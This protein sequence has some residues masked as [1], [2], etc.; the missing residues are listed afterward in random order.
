MGCL[1]QVFIHDHHGR[2]IYFETYSGQAPLGEYVLGLFEK[3]EDSLE[4]P[5]PKLPVTRAIVLDAGHNSVR[6]LRAFAA[7]EKYHYITSLDANQWNPRRVRKQGPPERYRW[8]EAT[9]WDAELELEDSRP[10][11]KGYIFVTRA[12]KIEW[13][14]GKETYLATSVPRELV[15]ASLVVKCYFD[16][17]P[18]EELSF[19]LLKAVGSLHRVAGYGKKRLADVRARRRAAELE[20][21]IQE[22]RARLAEPRR[23]IAEEEWK[24]AGLVLRERRLRARSEIVDGERILPPGEAEELEALGRRIRALKRKVRAIRK[25]H[26]ELRKLDRAET[27]WMRLRGKDVVY[28]VDVELDQIMTFFRVSLANLYTYLARLAGWSHLSLVRL[29]HSVLLLPGT[30][31]ETAESRRVILERNEREPETMEALSRVVE[32]LNALGIV[33][34]GRQKISFA[35]SGKD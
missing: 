2:P 9:L 31:E 3:I 16:R 28:K 20:G 17:W 7:Q 8:G 5:G 10:E 33:N 26:P 34:G 12:V 29:V 1:E 32:H 15:G 18:A 30:V 25:A 4:G 27:E 21:E 14:N 23:A 6:T 22:L 11:E 35:L 13:D 19:R 24:I